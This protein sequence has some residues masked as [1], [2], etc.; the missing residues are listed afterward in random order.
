MKSKFNPIIVAFA[1]PAIA[2]IL[3]LAFIFLKKTKNSSSA[4]ELPYAAFLE[5]PQAFFG[6]SYKLSAQIDS[7]LA[8][9]EGKGRIL[10]LRTSSNAKISVFLPKSVPAN[11]YPGQ[12]YNLYVDVDQSGMMI[13]R[14]LEKY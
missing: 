6:N 14:G 7:Q 13:V 9:D 3:A 1:I 10:S 5:N 2:I 12:W 4:E 8:F 11:L